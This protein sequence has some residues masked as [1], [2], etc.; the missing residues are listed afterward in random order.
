MKSQQT[1]YFPDVQ[2]IGDFDF[3]EN[4]I[5]KTILQSELDVFRA[6]EWAKARVAIAEYKATCSLFLALSMLLVIGVL[7]VSLL[8]KIDSQR[9]PIQTVQPE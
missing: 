6:E 2:T 5:A 8:G 9:L 1:D 7:S 4:D 3:D